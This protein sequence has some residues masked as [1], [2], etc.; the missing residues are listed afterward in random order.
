MLKRRPDTKLLLVGDGPDLAGL[1]ARLGGL[2]GVRFAG[3]VERGNLPQWYSAAD[4]FVFPSVTDT[5]GLVVLEAQACGLPALVSDQGGPQEIIL[6]GTSGFVLPE[7]NLNL[8]VETID[9]L[10]ELKATRPL[11]YR[12]MQSAARS[13]ALERYNLTAALSSYFDQAPNRKTA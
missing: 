5:F 6:P 7:A 8:W 2:A 3:R 9:S 10:I 1:Q 4:L 13:Q 12:Q 11:A